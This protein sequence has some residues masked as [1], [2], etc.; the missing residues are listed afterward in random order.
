MESKA[1]MI[2]LCVIY[3][4]RLKSFHVTYEEFLYLIY[5]RRLY[6]L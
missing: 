5:S 3:D 6:L 1:L 2:G 4:S